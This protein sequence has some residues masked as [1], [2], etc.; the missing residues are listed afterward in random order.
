M[1]KKRKSIA[2]R[3]DNEFVIH[4]AALTIGCVRRAGSH[5]TGLKL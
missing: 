5:V 3:R 4:G 1:Q 2:P